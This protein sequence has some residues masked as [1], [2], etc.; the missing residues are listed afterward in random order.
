MGMDRNDHQIRVLL[1]FANHP[2]DICS[3]LGV[4]VVAIGESRPQPKMAVEQIDLARRIRT[5]P[6][7]DRAVECS[8]MPHVLR[9]QFR[10]ERDMQGSDP[11]PSRGSPFR[12][13][14][15]GGGTKRA[16]ERNQRHASLGSFKILRCSSEPYCRAGSC[17]S[18]ARLIEPL[19][20]LL[21]TLPAPVHHVT[22]G[23]REVQSPW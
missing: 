8:Q 19:P 7:V 5:M 11:R 3:I 22:V 23:A 17:M 6:G 20:G 1:C 2:Q 16:R 18:D 12:R 13:K 4:D 21:H 15:I 9:R 14:R 10:G